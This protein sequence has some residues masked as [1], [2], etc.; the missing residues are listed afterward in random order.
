MHDAALLRRGWLALVALLPLPLLA[1]ASG[2]DVWL[3]GVYFDAAQ[4]DFPWR[5]VW[6]FNVFLHDGLRTLLVFL[7]VGVAGLLVLMALAPEYLSPYV[8]GNRLRPRVLAYLLVAMLAGPLVVALLK[9]VSVRPCPWS[10]EMFGGAA[11]YHSL[12]AVPLFDWHAGGQCFPGAHASGGFGLLAF[13]PLLSGWRRG[14]MLAGALVLGLFMGWTQMMQGAHFLSHNLWS[15]WICWAVTLVSYLLIH[16][17][18][19]LNDS[20]TK[21]RELG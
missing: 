19:E 17:G 20:T 7:V 4:R 14:A 13:V 10:L 21:I 6:W 9:Q 18:V 11:P 15:A 2:L 1:D 12:L 16:P 5:H 3:E 8:A